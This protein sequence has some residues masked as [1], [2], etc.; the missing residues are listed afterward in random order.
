MIASLRIV[1][2]LKVKKKCLFLK[3]RGKTPE[4]FKLL[5]HFRVSQAN[6]AGGPKSACRRR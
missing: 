1:A 6:L 5:T 2:R 4:P 3:N